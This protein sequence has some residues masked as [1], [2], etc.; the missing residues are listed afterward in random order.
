[1]PESNSKYTKLIIRRA[2]LATVG[3][4]ILFWALVHFDVK[5]HVQALFSWLEDLGAWAPVIF[6]AIYTLVVILVLPG[7]IFTLGAGFLFGVFQGFAYVV[8]ST[9]LGAVIA[10]FIGRRFLGERTRRWLQ[11]RPRLCLITDNLIGKGWK[12]I[13]LTRLTPLFPFKLS[14]YVLG[15]AH[16][17]FKDFFIGTFFGIWP[18]AFVNAYIGSMAADLATLD[19]ETAQ[20]PPWQWGIYAAGLVIMIILV[21]Y[22]A[23]TALEALNTYVPDERKENE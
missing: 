18:L 7:F 11:Q 9:T 20:R 13:F 21:L 5:E 10:F 1:M 2:V 19:T 16:F 12:V 22:I 23:R 3:L 4:G 6:M 8:I 14:N 17:S 15:L